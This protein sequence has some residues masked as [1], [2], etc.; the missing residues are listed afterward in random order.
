MSFKA[1]PSKSLSTDVSLA[2][3][4]IVGLKD[5]LGVFMERFSNTTREVAQGGR[6]GALMLTVSVHHPDIYKFMRIKNELDENGKRVKVTGANVSIRL[7][8]E[9]LTAVE[10]GDEVELRWPVDS[11]DPEVL[12]G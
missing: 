9:F 3:G 8:D 4:L 12:E 6:R 7:T 1:D 11:T 2:D 5:G 10:N